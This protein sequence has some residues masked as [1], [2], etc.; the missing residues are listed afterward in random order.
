MHRLIPLLWLLS[1][2][3]LTPA[4]APSAAAADVTIAH[5]ESPQGWRFDAA[6]TGAGTLDF[7]AFGRSWR[8]ELALNARL[9]AALGR[10][11]AA[12]NA[13]VELYRGRIAGQ[14]GS[15]LRLTRGGDGRWAGLMW[16]GTEL[17]A[18]ESAA[19]LSLAAGNGEVKADTANPAAGPGAAPVMFRLAD[20]RLAPGA[21]GCAVADGPASPA[22]SAKAGFDDLVSE[23]VKTVES[24]ID[25]AV[26]GDADFAAR[27][28]DPVAALATRLNNIDGIFSE[29]VGVTINVTDFRVFS[30]ANDPFT[31]S[32]DPTTLLAELGNYKSGE[33]D[34]RNLG[35]V[36]LYTGRDLDDSTAGIAYTR[37]LCSTRFGAGLSEGRRTVTT[38]SLIGAHEIGHNFGSPHDGEDGSVCENTPQNF[39]MAPRLNGSSTFS[40]CSLEQMAPQVASAFCLKALPDA[41][42]TVAAVVSPATVLE[43]G[44]VSLE[45]TA[46]NLGTA[47]AE[48]VSMSVGL[49]AGVSLRDAGTLCTAAAGGAECTIGTVAAGGSATANLTLAAVD[50]GPADLAAEVRADS[51]TEPSNNTASAAL[52]IDPAADLGI[53]LQAPASV[54]R[55][56]RATLD[57]TVTNASLRTATGLVVTISTPSFL[58]PA[59]TSGSAGCTVTAGG[60]RC[61]AAA[62]AGGD[63]LALE[64]SVDAAQEGTGAVEAVVRAAQGDPD[65]GDNT[66]SRSIE[67]SSTAAA[68]SAGGGGGGHGLWLLLLTAGF[69]GAARR[70]A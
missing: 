29:Q 42:M 15:W 40:A 69:L 44:T 24:E 46:S 21:L 25:L 45:L 53:A 64:L 70:S 8:L 7:T 67:V 20:M 36:H 6:P 62:L 10:S 43:G 38:D 32:T 51:D 61:E 54:T 65:E 52:R 17:Y 31:D 27:H 9:S 26:L 23:L 35:L 28:P 11:P 13:G 1:L 39:L 59:A 22:G 4:L 2:L 50:A 33:P 18:L 58:Q 49:P 47:T 41:D 37:A 68:A 57:L 34:L 66:A 12:R 16:D 14:P 19:A 63:T 30:V 3:S 56:A 5:H 60:I 48:L 55:G